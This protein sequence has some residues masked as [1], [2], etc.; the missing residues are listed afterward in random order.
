MQPIHPFQ[1]IHCNVTVRLLTAMFVVLAATGSPDVATAEQTTALPIL[2]PCKQTAVPEL[3]AR[4]RAVGLMM[5]FVRQQLD[6]GEFVYDGSLPAMRATLYGLESGAV[7]LLITDKE[8]YQLSGPHDSPDACIALGQKYTAP[9]A[10]WLSGNA[11][12]DGEAPLSTTPVQWWKTS[13][14]DGRTR[15][16]WY[17][18]DTRLPWRTMF[19]SRS[20][21]PAVFGDYGITYFPTFGPLAETKLAQL[22]DLCASK[23]QK[24]TGATAAAGTAR[25]LMTIGTD[26]TEPERA[27]RIQALVP[28]LSRQACSSVNTPR[29]PD[30]FVMTG[31]L[32]PIPFKWTPLPSM[33]YYDWERAGTLYAWMHEARSLPPVLELVSVLT[34]GVGYSVERAPNRA[35]V[36]AAKSPGVV[37]PD[38]MSVA[39]C[40]CKGVIDRNADLGPNEV[41]QI[42]ACPIKGQG[43]R[44]IWS[45]Y[46]AT[47]RPI[48]FAEPG[49]IGSGINIA[50]YFAW[51]PGEKMPQGTFELPQLCTRATEAGLPPVGYGLPSAMTASCVDCHTTRQ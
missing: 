47:G 34:K 32:S 36:C 50:D 12:C 43:L 48:L 7:D 24:A 20:T 13:A 4:W 30:Q 8:T 28:G 5:P 19:P 27:E 26:I 18:T 51:R 21:D 14:A 17:K 37:R 9:T 16:Q 22:R 41:S 2:S 40:E 15:W 49:A 42:R 1:R 11:V 35:F 38:W 23:A 6:V 31:I 10:R 33:I 25:E 29:W 46:T 39:G 3:P 45:W 44:G